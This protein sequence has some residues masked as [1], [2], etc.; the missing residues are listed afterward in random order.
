MSSLFTG[1]VSN[2]KGKYGAKGGGDGGEEVEIGNEIRNKRDW[3]IE[4]HQRI[5][6]PAI[7][8]FE[9]FPRFL[10]ISIVSDLRD[11]Q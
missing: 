8:K 6:I 3:K 5:L 7:S 1:L 9:K 2:S 10:E 4:I 11:I